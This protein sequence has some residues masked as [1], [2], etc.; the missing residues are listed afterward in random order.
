MELL[1]YVEPLDDSP[2]AADPE[3]SPM[4]PRGRKRDARLDTIAL[5]TSHQ[6]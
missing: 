6:R 1:E 4:A 3:V 2:A 5:Q